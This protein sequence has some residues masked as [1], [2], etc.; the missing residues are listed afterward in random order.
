MV[1]QKVMNVFVNGDSCQE[2]VLHLV[3]RENNEENYDAYVA[4]W[5]NDYTTYIQRLSK[6]FVLKCFV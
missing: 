2:K 1:C 3:A 5:K 4:E 6:A